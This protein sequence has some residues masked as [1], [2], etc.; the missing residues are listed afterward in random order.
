[1]SGNQC[2]VCGANAESADEYCRGCGAELAGSGKLK[3]TKKKIGSQDLIVI[4]GILV[5]FGLTYFAFFL[6]PGGQTE[7]HEHSE[8]A[9]MQGSLADFN[10]MAASQPDNYDELVQ[11]GNK[12]MD[13]RNYHMAVLSY[14][15]AVARDSTSPDILTDLGACYHA[16]G[17]PEAAL[18]MFEKAIGL[19][20]EHVIAHFNMGI[21][22]HGLNDLEKTK[23]YW[24]KVIELHPDEPIADTVR[25]YLSQLAR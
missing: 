4:F 13:N 2:P 20:P 15:R 25:K 24:N 17:N 1:M 11:L 22:Y 3:E 21:V 19:N 18:K 7:G 12:F 14:E 6:K 8:L 5:V 10:Q 23:Y 16:L 9:G